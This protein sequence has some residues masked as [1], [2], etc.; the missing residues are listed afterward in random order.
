MS[1]CLDVWQPVQV[2]GV[3]MHALPARGRTAAW[4]VSQTEV[5]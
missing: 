4:L 3:T 1:Y 2:Y 5:F